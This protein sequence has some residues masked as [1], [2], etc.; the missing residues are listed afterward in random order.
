MSITSS[1]ML[2]SECDVVVIGA[3]IAGLTSSALLAKSGLK[4][5][6]VEEQ[7]RAGGYF[8]SFQ[9][10][11]YSFDSSV[12]WLNQCGEGGLVD[13]I[14]QHI[15][16]DHPVCKNMKRIHRYKS[17]SFDYV[18]T[19]EPDTL[20]DQLVRDHPDDEKGIVR[21]FEDCRRIGTHFDKL[22]ANM[23]VIETMPFLE[24]MLFGLKMTLWTIP[25]WKYFGMPA[26]KGIQ[27]YFYTDGMKKIFCSEEKFMSII[28]PICWAYIKDFQA[29]PEGG[30]TGVIADWLC[31]KI[32]QSSSHVILNCAVEKIL[33]SGK[34]AMGVSLADGRTISS[35]YIIAACDLQR[36]YERMLPAGAVPEKLIRRIRKT[37]LYHSAVT[38]FL[39]LNCDVSS[40]GLHEEVTCITREGVIRTDH[41]GK[42]PDKISLIVQAP[43]VRD[44]SL[45]PPGKSTVTIHCAAWMDYED[46]WKTEKDFGR[47][48]AYR[49]LKERYADIL[50]TRV[51]GAMNVNLR[52]YIEVMEIATPVTYWRYSGNRE[53]SIMGQRPTVQNIFKRVAHYRT[54]VKNIFIGGHWAEY[55]GGTAIAVKA[56]S[57]A[58][59][60]I[61][62]EMKKKEFENLRNVM[63]GR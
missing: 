5:A 14:F 47:G 12:Q 44:P 55:G 52:K 49:G 45:A 29:P 42:D 18:L 28:M 34:R 32:K 16:P 31:G 26:E 41:S 63:D 17:E 21:F 4:V 46:R 6:L 11:G 58:S 2:P 43:S 19:N 60:L 23:R 56:A 39:G 20:R 3:G 24:R 57:N 36:L 27:R 51:E 13:R 50:I 25:V 37:D 53:G 30:G 10:N 1:S 15:G 61:L 35:R 33:M 62:R 7:P 22:K 40:L 38:I 8:V 54:P 9:R 48:K 59:L